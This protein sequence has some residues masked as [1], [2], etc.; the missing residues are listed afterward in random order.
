MEEK[1][2][3]TNEKA[4][5][6]KKK[7]SSK[8]K[9]ITIASV[10]IGIVAIIAILIGINHTQIMSELTYSMMPKSINPVVDGQEVTFFVYKNKDFNQFKDK[11]TP[12]KAF[13]FYYLD[14]NGKNIDLSW[15]KVYVGSKGTKFTPN[16]WFMM[17][18]NEKL[19]KVKSV[20]SKV[21]PI[22][23]ILFVILLIYLWFK[24][25]CK[26]E[27]ARMEALYGKKEDR[28][29]NSKSKKKK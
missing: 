8:N 29:N 17:K 15:D 12:L 10:V 22:V 13:G 19:T 18:A 26:R 14:E 5:K 9:K 25:W 3:Q 27:D 7:M 28:H 1:E 6:A 21:I 23:V 2:L 24:N 11:E 20:S 4:V 16:V